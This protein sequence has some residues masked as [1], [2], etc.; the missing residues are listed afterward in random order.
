MFEDLI[1]NEPEEKVALDLCSYITNQD[2]CPHYV[3]AEDAISIISCEYFG[4]LTSY[5]YKEIGD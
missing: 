2:K 5:C 4:C 3:Y 1:E